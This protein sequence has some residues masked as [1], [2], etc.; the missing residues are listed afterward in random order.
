VALPSKPAQASELAT[1]RGPAP[2]LP[3]TEASDHGPD[4]GF[5][6]MSPVNG[7]AGWW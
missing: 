6:A 4:L 2:R 5:I 3:V 7:R 1:V